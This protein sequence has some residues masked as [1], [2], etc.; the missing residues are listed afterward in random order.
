MQQ[1]ALST[2]VRAAL[3]MA[4]CV[5]KLIVVI[6]QLATVIYDLRVVVAVVRN[7]VKIGIQ[8]HIARNCSKL[9]LNFEQCMSEY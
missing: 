3:R 9:S 6:V 8:T 2:F 4:N 1:M 5:C 7:S